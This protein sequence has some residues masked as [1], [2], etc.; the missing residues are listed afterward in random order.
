MGVQSAGGTEEVA[1]ET[2]NNTA[3]D[4]F[5]QSRM[6]ARHG[7]GLLVGVPERGEGQFP[8]GIGRR[9]TVLILIPIVGEVAYPIRSKCKFSDVEMASQIAQH[10]IRPTF[11]LL[12]QPVQFA[13]AGNSHLFTAHHGVKN[14]VPSFHVAEQHTADDGCEMIGCVTMVERTPNRGPGPSQKFTGQYFFEDGSHT[15]LALELLE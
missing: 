6:R 3:P 7:Q 13:V 11:G 5:V 9:N 8:Y 12:S 1:A 14:A 15:T 4:T 2:G 10:F